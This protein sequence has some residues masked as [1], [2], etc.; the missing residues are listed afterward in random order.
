M[1]KKEKQDKKF[2][3]SF[4]TG[5]REAMEKHQQIQEA[6][7]DAYKKGLIDGSAHEKTDRSEKEEDTAD[8]GKFEM[9]P[10]EKA[11]MDKKHKHSKE[12]S[13]NDD[14][15]KDVI[16]IIA[17][18]EA[19][20]EQFSKLFKG[21][22]VQKE[23]AQVANKTS[24]KLELKSVG[25]VEAKP[26][27]KRIDEIKK[28]NETN[29]ANETKMVAKTKMVNETKTTFETKKSNETAKPVAKAA[30]ATSIS[31]QNTTKLAQ[32]SEN[33]SK[34]SNVTKNVTKAAPKLVK[35]KVQQI[36]S[37]NLNSEVNSVP[38]SHT[39]TQADN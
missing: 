28:S 32:K 27:A 35:S 25:K 16:K 34:Q 37:N 15:K 26:E 13:K 10:S 1:S 9:L 23:S 29:K 12:K 24:V 2:A 6:A 14:V 30:I 38:I 19:K 17:R 22:L 5:V 4:G 20:K 33:M 7:R 36:E 8:S 39:F 18:E 21:S 3:E 11:K 31:K